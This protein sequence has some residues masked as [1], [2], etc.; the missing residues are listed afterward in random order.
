M[1]HA[2]DVKQCK[3]RVVYL[4]YH[5]IHL[6]FFHQLKDSDALGEVLKPANISALLFGHNHDGRV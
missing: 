6:T 4:H 1:L 5:P 3:Y 2:D